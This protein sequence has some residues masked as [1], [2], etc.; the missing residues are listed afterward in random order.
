MLTFLGA[1][2]RSLLV[3]E[4]WRCY[5]AVTGAERERADDELSQPRA[6]AELP[7]FIEQRGPRSLIE[8][9]A[10]V[11]GCKPPEALIARE[12]IAA[13][14]L[15]QLFADAMIRPCHQRNPVAGQLGC[16][17]LPPPITIEPGA[18]NTAALRRSM[19]S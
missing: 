14:A 4:R 11:L 12:Q 18:R 10:A 3:R 5:M 9:D 17:S 1:K 7:L 13:Q 15:D 2:R 8:G 19:S 6:Q 16:L